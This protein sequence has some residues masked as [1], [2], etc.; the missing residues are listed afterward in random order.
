MYI[1]W[2][3][4]SYERA[5]LDDVCDASVPSGRHDEVA[6]R[7][8]A[9]EQKGHVAPRRSERKFK[10]GCVSRLFSVSYFHGRKAFILAHI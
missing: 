3:G 5:I 7:T 2:G 1:F 6:A 9:V 4:A 8:G 10:Q